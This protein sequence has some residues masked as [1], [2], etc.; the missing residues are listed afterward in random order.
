M[1]VSDFEWDDLKDWENRLKHEVSFAMA[2]LAF[3][4]RKRIIEED[5]KHGETEPRYYC[6][7]WVRSGVLTVRFTY[8]G[9]KIRIFGAAYWRKGRRIY[10]DENKIH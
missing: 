3:A 6:Y 10:E 4:D 8:R 2:Q 1:K 7:G 9:K 5:L